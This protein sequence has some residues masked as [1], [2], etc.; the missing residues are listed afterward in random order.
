[1]IDLKQGDCLEIMKDITD[2]S[3]D[4]ILADLP[5]GLVRCEW[6]KKIPLNLLWEQYNRIV[7]DNG[8]VVLFSQMPF[9]AELVMSNPKHFKYMWIWYKR[10]IAEIF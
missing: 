10:I 7:K 6:D 9:T 5:Y 4:M 8:A 2:R 1:M 3:I